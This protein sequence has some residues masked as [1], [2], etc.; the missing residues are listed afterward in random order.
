MSLKKVLYSELQNK[1]ILMQDEVEAIA[2]SEGRKISNAERRL[3]ELMESGIVEP[4][5][6]EKKAIRGYRYIGKDQ[7]SVKI[8]TFPQGVMKL[9]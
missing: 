6:T 3:R 2:K 4:I 9:L 1:K 8:L 7:P 5:L